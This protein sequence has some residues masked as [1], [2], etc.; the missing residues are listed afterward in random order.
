MYCPAKSNQPK[1]GSFDRSKLKSEA[2]R[3]LENSTRPPCC[4]RPLKSVRLLAIWKQIADGA[5]RTVSS[6]LHIYYIK[7]LAT[8]VWTN[9]ES[10]C[11]GAMNIFSP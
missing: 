3:F 8:A 10:V 4:E 7:L 5:H 6:L 2:R 9:L 1:L 11:N